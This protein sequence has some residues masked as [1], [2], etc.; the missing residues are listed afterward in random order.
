MFVYIYE[1]S[2]VAWEK[3]RENVRRWT[4][5]EV[6]K[7]FQVLADPDNGCAFCLEKFSAE[8]II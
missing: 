1:K 5:E 6:E 7:F 4:K 2:K 3:S 8:E